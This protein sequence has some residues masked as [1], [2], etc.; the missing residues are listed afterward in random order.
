MGTDIAGLLALMQGNKG[1]DLPG[2]LALCQAIDAVN[3]A[4]RDQGDRTY[5]ATR[6]VGD[7]VRDCCCKLE[8][9]LASIGCDLNGLGR[10]VRELGAH[11]DAK[12]ELE[13]LKAENARAAMECRLTQQQQDCCCET[14]AAIADLKAT[15]AADRMLDENARLRRENDQLREAARGDAIATAAVNAMQKFA[16]DHWTPTRTGGAAGA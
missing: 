15:I 5:D 11:V 1:M 14:Q 3:A 16:M 9:Q 12:I 2:L 6:N 4:T 7:A 8:A 10:D 13:A